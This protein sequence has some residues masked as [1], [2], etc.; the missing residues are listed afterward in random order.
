MDTIFWCHSC[1]VVMIYTIYLDVTVV[2]W[3]GYYNILMSLLY[4]GMDMCYIL[5][6][7]L[8]CVKATIS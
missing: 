2:L 7:L 4:C 3:Y 8:Y 5:M 6:S 1:I